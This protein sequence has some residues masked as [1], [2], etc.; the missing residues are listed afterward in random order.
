MRNI[1]FSQRLRYRFD[2]IMARGPIALI[3]WLF[4]LSLLLIVIIALVMMALGLNQ[5]PGEEIGFGSLL[6]RNLMR[7]LDAGTM[8]ADQGTPGFLLMMLLVT[9]G[10]IFVVSILIGVLTSGIEGQIEALRKGRSFVV[11]NNHT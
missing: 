10:G 8:G 1:T 5:T 3:G 2:N 11:E 7:T 9:M 4:L 6:W